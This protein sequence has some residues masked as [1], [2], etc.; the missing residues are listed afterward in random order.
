MLRLGDFEVITLA[1]TAVARFVRGLEFDLEPERTFEPVGVF[2]L[3][4]TTC[5]LPLRGISSTAPLSSYFF[6]ESRH[7]GH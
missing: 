1:L 7:T 3:T 6:L 4:K 2:S 5:G